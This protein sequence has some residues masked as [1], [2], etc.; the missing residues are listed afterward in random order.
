[1]GIYG[2]H[3]IFPDPHP[4]TSHSSSARI[5]QVAPA[6][7]PW[8]AWR[9]RSSWWRGAWRISCARDVNT[10]SST[11]TWRFRH[12]KTI[13]KPW[14]NGGLFMGSH[15]TMLV[16]HG[17]EWDLMGFTLWWCQNSYWTW[18]LIVDFPIEHVVFMGHV[19]QAKWGTA[20][21]CLNI[22]ENA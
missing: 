20:I 21:V 4:A 7:R 15:R 16:F 13:G 5:V 10:R 22:D 6:V 8:T 3:D 12:G 2:F 14:E 17:I 18:P 11:A 9:K 1:M 19:Q